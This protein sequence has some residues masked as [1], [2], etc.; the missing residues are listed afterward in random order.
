MSL[1]AICVFG[2]ALSACNTKKTTL[3][4]QQK[5][6]LQEQQKALP[7]TLQIES[8]AYSVTVECTDVAKTEKLKNLHWVV[9][10][11]PND[12]YL[13]SQQNFD[14]N[15]EDAC[16]AVETGSVKVNEAQAVFTVSQRMNAQNQ[17]ESVT[18]A[19]SKTYFL[20]S[21]DRIFDKLTLIDNTDKNVCQGKMILTL[22]K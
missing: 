18:T 19:T 2:F 8:G 20:M 12:Q 9:T 1:A 16:S 3:T 11:K 14:P 21:Y 13:E 22:Q 7:N 4:S 10:F 15:C 5:E 17:F 6:L